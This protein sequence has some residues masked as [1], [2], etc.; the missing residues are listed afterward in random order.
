MPT[1]DVQEERSAKGPPSP[2]C[3]MRPAA[4]A[5]APNMTWLTIDIFSSRCH[6]A[7]SARCRSWTLR[8]SSRERNTN[9]T[10]TNSGIAKT[11]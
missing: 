5:A 1:G 8:W 4:I 11:R 10:R 7:A 2:T 9:H 6:C 3:T